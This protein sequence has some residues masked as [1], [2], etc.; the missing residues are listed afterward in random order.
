MRADIDGFIGPNGIWDSESR[1]C[2]GGDTKVELLRGV[3]MIS[4]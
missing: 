2:H 1:R 3:T 4:D